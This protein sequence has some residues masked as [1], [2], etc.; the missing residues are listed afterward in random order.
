MLIYMYIYI[1]IGIEGIG[2]VGGRDGCRGGRER[3]SDSIYRAGSL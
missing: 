3:A 1:P 2:W